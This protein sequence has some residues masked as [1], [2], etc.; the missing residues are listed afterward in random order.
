MND[1]IKYSLLRGW[2][3]NE[4]SQ[5]NS[6][7]RLQQVHVTELTET[8]HCNCHRQS[9]GFTKIVICMTLYIINVHN[10]SL[11]TTL[12]WP[13]LKKS[14]SATIALICIRRVMADFV[15]KKQPN[16]RSHGN[17]GLSRENVNSTIKSAVPENPMFGAN[18][19]ALVFLQTE[20]CP[21]LCENSP[22]FVTMVTRVGPRKIWMAPLIRPSPKT[23][24]LVQTRR[25]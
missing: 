4:C 11:Y 18:S 3:V 14:Y 5:C 2:Q 19:A 24:C 22:I 10:W 25:L 20:L 6:W 23:S 15:Q 16:F 17:K 1:A 12:N 8:R 13:C 9:P 7:Q 21:V